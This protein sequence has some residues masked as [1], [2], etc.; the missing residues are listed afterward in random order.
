MTSAMDYKS[1]DREGRRTSMLV[2]T[3]LLA[4]VPSLS[5]TSEGRANVSQWLAQEVERLIDSYAGPRS[6]CTEP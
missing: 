5:I 3:S 2:L 1:L 6:N 4:S